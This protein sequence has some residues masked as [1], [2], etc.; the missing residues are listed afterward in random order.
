M[1]AP[2]PQ[3]APPA[4]PVAA[5]VDPTDGAAIC[6][7][8]QQVM[9]PMEEV[10]ISWCQPVAHYVHHDCW[11]A[12]PERF[13]ANCQLCQQPEV[14][15]MVLMDVCTICG[16]VSG[17]LPEVLEQLPPAGRALMRRFLNKEVTEV[18]IQQRASIA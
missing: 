8:C 15:E 2:P 12:Q 9:W 6:F 17:P 14:S 5:P 10:S 7:I 16:V 18:D 3:P 13:K 11:N 1:A 4:P